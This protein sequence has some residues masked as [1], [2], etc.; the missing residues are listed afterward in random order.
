MCKEQDESVCHL[1]FYFKVAQQVWDLC[2]RWIGE[3]LVKHKQPKTHYQ[4][5]ISL[6]LSLSL[7]LH[8]T[9]AR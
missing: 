9:A 5:F 4:H 3:C 8:Y 1:F 2:D 7:S 6:S